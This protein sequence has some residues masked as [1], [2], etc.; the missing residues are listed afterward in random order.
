LQLNVKKADEYSSLVLCPD[1]VLPNAEVD[2]NWAVWGV[3]KAILSVGVRRKITLTLTAQDLS[4]NFQGAG[5]WRVDAGNEK[6]TVS[7]RVADALND[8][9]TVNRELAVTKWVPWKKIGYTGK[10]IAM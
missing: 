4:R 3:K 7:L 2:L 6:E 9:L 1:K 5:I 10:P 8:K